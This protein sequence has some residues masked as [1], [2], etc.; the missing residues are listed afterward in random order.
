MVGLPCRHSQVFLERRYNLLRVLMWS[1]LRVLG[2]GQ[3]KTIEQHSSGG[4][5]QGTSF[6][7]KRL[8]WTVYYNI[9]P[10]IYHPPGNRSGILQP[11]WCHLLWNTPKENGPFVDTTHNIYTW[12]FFWHHTTRAKAPTTIRSCHSHNPATLGVR[13]KCSGKA[14]STRHSEERTEFI[15]AQN[16]W[17]KRTKVLVN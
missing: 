9:L 5:S 2:S 8:S 16:L 14:P 1:S 4:F 12:A 11:S 3:V 13:P 6:S 17:N 7:Q 15:V 10:I